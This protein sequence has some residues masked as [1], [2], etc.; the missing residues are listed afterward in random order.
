MI[1]EQIGGIQIFILFNCLDFHAVFVRCPTHH[2]F[3]FFRRKGLRCAV[4][5]GKTRLK[6]KVLRVILV[7]HA[8]ISGVKS[9]GGRNHDQ[10]AGSEYRN[11]GQSHGIL[12]HAVEQSRNRRHILGAVI[13]ILILFQRFQHKNT[14]RDKE[15]IGADNHQQHRQKEDRQRFQRRLCHQGNRVT[16]AE[17]HE[18]QSQHDPSDL[19]FLFADAAALQQFH[20]LHQCNADTVEQENTEVEQQKKYRRGYHCTR[21]DI[22]ESRHRVG[23]QQ[24]ADHQRTQLI[25]NRSRTKSSGNRQQTAEQVFKK[26]HSSHMTLLHAQHI[27]HAELPFALFHQKAVDVEHQ[28]RREQREN[29]DPHPHK[30]GKILAAFHTPHSVVHRQR[31]HDVKTGNQTGFRPHPRREKPGI[32]SDILRCHLRIQ[33]HLTSPPFLSMV[34]VSE[35]F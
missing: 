17:R 31:Q 9:D 7:E 32:A 4:L 6:I 13:E 3:Q 24:A 14:S 15:K 1:L 22:I 11:G 18:P 10:H 26:Q 29:S 30:S 19:R 21:R 8:L 27:I 28:H 23:L 25:E 2:A 34:S 5:L 16:A 33:S 35:I 20:R 12:L